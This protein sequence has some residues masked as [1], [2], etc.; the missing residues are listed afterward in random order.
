[1]DLP[2]WIPLWLR[3]PPEPV[4]VP[5]VPLGTLTVEQVLMGRQ[6]DQRYSHEFTPTIAANVTELVRRVNLLLGQYGKTPK[7]NS[8]WRPPAVNTAVGGAKGSAHLTGQAVDLSDPTQSLQHWIAA[9]LHELELAGLWAESF[10]A[11]PTWCHLQ[12]RRASTL[13]FKP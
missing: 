6:N 7:V 10:E 9:N 4:F 2:A 3:R 1:M 12:S 8:G 11:T 13:L 5:V